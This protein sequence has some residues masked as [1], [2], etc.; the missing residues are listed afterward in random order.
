MMMPMMTTKTVIFDT[1][2]RDATDLGTAIGIM[3]ELLPA[4]GQSHTTI[5]TTKNH[6]ENVY[7]TV[8][9]STNARTSGNGPAAA[10]LI[11]K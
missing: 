3:T 4:V 5:M 8:M 9:T 6:T 7:D 2:L 10:L 11:V 1:T